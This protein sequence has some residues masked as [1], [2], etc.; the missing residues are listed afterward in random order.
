MVDATY[1]LVLEGHSNLLIGTVDAAQH[2]HTIGYAICSKEDTEAHT[3]AITALRVE[4]E[5]LVAERIKRQ[6]RI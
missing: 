2:W 1:R 6:E 4:V 3:N 5:L